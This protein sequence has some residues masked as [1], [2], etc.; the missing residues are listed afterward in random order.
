MSGS[1]V[2]AI[3]RGDIINDND[4]HSLVHESNENRNY[5]DIK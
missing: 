5:G 2:I 3:I 4:N 1:V